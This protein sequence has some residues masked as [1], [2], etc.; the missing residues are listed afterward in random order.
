MF[1][2]PGSGLIDAA[3]LP[4]LFALGSAHRLQRVPVAIFTQHATAFARDWGWVRM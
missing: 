4:V 1:I 2:S 3:S